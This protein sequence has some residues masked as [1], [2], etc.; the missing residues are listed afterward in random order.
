MAWTASNQIILLSP[1]VLLPY[2]FVFFSFLADGRPVEKPFCSNQLMSK[3]A[4]MT[5]RSVLWVLQYFTPLC[6]ITFV[7]ARMALRLWGSR[8]PGTAH[9]T[10]D[11]TI[12]RNKKKVNEGAALGFGGAS[13]RMP[14]AS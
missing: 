6:I 3:E 5:Y 13:F 1:F 11:A 8:T 7:Y 2:K 14:M 4:M 12:M 10:R 9:D